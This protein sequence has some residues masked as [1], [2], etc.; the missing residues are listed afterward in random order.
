GPVGIVDPG[1]PAFGFPLLAMLP[2]VGRADSY[3]VR[4]DETLTVPAAGVLANDR[5]PAGRPLTTVLVRGPAHG[6]LT[7]DPGGGFR[8]VPDPNFNGRDSFLYAVTD[9]QL[10]SD[11]AAVTLTVLAVPDPLVRRGAVLVVPGMPSETAVVRFRWLAQKAMFRDE[12]GVLL[13]DDDQGRI[14]GLRPDDPRFL[15]VALKRRRWISLFR[16]G[17]GVGAVRH[18]PIPAGQRMVLVVVRNG[19]AHPFLSRKGRNA[20]RAAPVLFFMNPADNPDQAEHVHVTGHSG[21]IRLAWEDQLH[22]GDHDFNDMVI[23]AHVL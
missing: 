20:G 22:G 10:E 23:S 11:P 14:N 8:Y 7:L 18:L 2:P 4:E 1:G 12:L 16:Q 19:R 15:A 6:R 3:S 13:V 17:Q 21:V 9:G 5:G